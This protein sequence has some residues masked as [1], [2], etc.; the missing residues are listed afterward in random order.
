M[1]RGAVEENPDVSGS[2]VCFKDVAPHSPKSYL[3]VL[4]H[5]T[6]DSKFF[7]KGVF[8][9]ESTKPQTRLSNHTTIATEI[10]IGINNNRIL[11]TSSK[12]ILK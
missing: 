4:A 10:K 7:F 2:S 12:K 3:V 11:K 6:G 8:G 1:S 9:L 5:D